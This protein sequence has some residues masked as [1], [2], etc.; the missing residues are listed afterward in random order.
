[1]AVD[2]IDSDEFALGRPTKL[3][4]KTLSFPIFDSGRFSS[5]ES[6]P[7]GQSFFLVR[8]PEEGTSPNRLMLIENWHTEF[9]GPR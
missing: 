3:M 5:F 8:A 6:G 9:E 7:D 4:Q 1:M 2:V